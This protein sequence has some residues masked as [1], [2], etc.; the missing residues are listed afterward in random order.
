MLAFGHDRCSAG[1]RAGISAEQARAEAARCISGRVAPA[2][3]D[4]LCARRRSRWPAST[5]SRPLSAQLAQSATHPLR[6]RRRRRL[7]A[8]DGLRSRRAVLTA[9]LDVRVGLRHLDPDRR[10]LW[11][12]RLDV[13]ESSRPGT[14]PKN[15]WTVAALQPRGRRSSD[16]AR[17]ALR[18]VIFGWV[19]TPRCVPVTTPTP[20]RRRRPVCSGR[21][22]A[23]PQ[24]PLVAG[25]VAPAGRGCARDLVNLASAIARGG[26]GLFDFSYFGSPIDTSRFTA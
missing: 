9:E 6:S 18:A 15:G 24:V 20:S 10:E 23:R 17:L 19:W 5:T 22:T 11:S 16:G 13:A 7:R 14:S 21:P 2:A 25:A 4:P 3:T 8:V 26:V 12:E 1:R